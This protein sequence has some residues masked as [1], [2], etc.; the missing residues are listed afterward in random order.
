MAS[1]DPVNG[2]GDASSRGS[3]L[4]ASRSIDLQTAMR[5]DIDLSELVS[6]GSNDDSGF[7]GPA[8]GAATTSV[9]GCSSCSGGTD[10]GVSSCSGNGVSD[11]VQ[12]S[13]AALSKNSPKAADDAS[14]SED[15]S[16][17]GTDEPDAVDEQDQ[18][19]ADGWSLS[20]EQGSTVATGDVLRQF[21]EL[22]IDFS[23]TQT[24]ATAGA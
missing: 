18:D 22:I 10:G 2:I 3:G 23:G 13:V 12:A 16:V 9:S 5:R 19:M 24:V 20:E 7:S 1:P 11:L 17:G 21:G 6:E 15:T 14:D 4:T 8:F